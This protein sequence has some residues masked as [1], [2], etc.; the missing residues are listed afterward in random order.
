MAKRPKDRF[1]ADRSMQN[2]SRLS[3]DRRGATGTSVPISLSS[4]PQEFSGLMLTVGM[5]LVFEYQQSTIMAVV[6]ELRALEL[7][8]TSSKTGPSAACH[9][10]STHG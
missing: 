10:I 5:I 1:E 2:T 3:F 6:K 9:T 8:T 4:R 7:K